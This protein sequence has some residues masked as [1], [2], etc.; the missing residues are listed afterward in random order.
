MKVDLVTKVILALIA[1]NLSFLSL[2]KLNIFP[3]AMASHSSQEQFHSEGKQF[4]FIPVNEDGSI[5]VRLADN[6]ELDVN[7]TGVNTWDEL[8][9]KLEE[10][11][12]S[13]ILNVNIEEVDGRGVYG[14]IPVEVD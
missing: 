1:I 7:I 12:T 5:N 14:S 13:D 6:E 4:T 3:N 2:Q 10:V 9:V 11:N 8:E